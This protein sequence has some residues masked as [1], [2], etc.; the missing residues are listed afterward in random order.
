MEYENYSFGEA[1]SHLAE[2]AGVV[3]PKIEYSREARAKAEKRAT[4]LE[5]NKKAAQYFYY[6][7]C[8]DNG[9]NAHDYLTGRGLSEETIKK[10]GLG[11]S[12]KY[13][14]D[15]Y[16]YL[17]AQNYSDELLRE[18]GLFNVDERQGMYDK[19]WNR[20]IFPIMDVNN[21]KELSDPV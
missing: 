19:F 3:L 8:R 4:L 5:I 16:K 15:L 1:L 7:L 10:F 6:Q 18:S 14:D 9:K 20:V 12:D 21:K 11:Y 17:K 13:S 2:R